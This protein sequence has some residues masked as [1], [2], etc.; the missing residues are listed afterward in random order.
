MRVFF[1][2]IILASSFLSSGCV[3][4]SHA[5]NCVL[6]NSQK[7]CFVREVWGHNG[8]RVA[9]TT[10]ENVCHQPQSETDFVSD[11]LGAGHSVYYKIDGET[12]RIYG[13]VGRMKH[14]R[15]PFPVSVEFENLMNPEEDILFNNGYSR[16]P[17][18]EM[19]WCFSDLK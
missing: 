15:K 12:L 1:I 2:P 7:V 16:L 17:L 10:S 11:A 9:L 18:E 3:H 4:G 8:D 5:I 19:T 6:V 13:S 14:P